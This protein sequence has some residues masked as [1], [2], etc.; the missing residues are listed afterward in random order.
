MNEINQ[1]LIRKLDKVNMI[2]GAILSAITEKGSL[3]KDEYNLIYARTLAAW[4]V[5]HATPNN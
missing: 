4:Q 3:T 2:N 1:E 5:K